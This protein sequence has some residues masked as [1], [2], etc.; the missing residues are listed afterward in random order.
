MKLDFDIIYA[1]AWLTDLAGIE[2]KKIYKK[3]LV[4][5]F[6]SLVYDRVGGNPDVLKYLYDYNYEIEL[7]AV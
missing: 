6:H 3:P 4:V 5:H 1:Y 2:I 7:E